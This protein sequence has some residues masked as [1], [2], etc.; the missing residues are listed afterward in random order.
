MNPKAQA[1][2]A[3]WRAVGAKRAKPDAPDKLE[4]KN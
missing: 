2:P 4:K 3:D 1:K